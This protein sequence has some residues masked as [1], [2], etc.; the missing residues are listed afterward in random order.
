MLR[1]TLAQEEATVRTAVDELLI[2]QQ[3]DGLSI[4]HDQEKT[5]R[6]LL[7]TP[8]RRFLFLEGGGVAALV[9]LIKAHGLDMPLPASLLSLSRLLLLCCQDAESAVTVGLLGL[10]PW[11]QRVLALNNQ[12]EDEE[13]EDE[14]VEALRECAE[15]IASRCARVRGGF[16]L[17]TLALCSDSAL[18][19]LRLPV[20]VPIHSHSSITTTQK[21]QEH[22]PKDEE[23]VV[24][25]TPIAD[26]MGSQAD[27]GYFLWP[28]ATI[29]ARF[30]V[31]NPSLFAGK[32]VME[33][34]AGLGLCGL[35][36]GRVAKE[37][38][39]TDYN[40]AC[41]QQLQE[42]VRLNCDDATGG[43][44]EENRVVSKEGG[45]AATAAAVVGAAAPGAAAALACPSTMKVRWLDWDRLEALSGST[46][47][48]SEEAEEEE[49]EGEEGKEEEKTEEDEEKSC[50]SSSL[51][52]SLSKEED[53]AFGRRRWSSGLLDV[54]MG[55]D[56][57]CD[58]PSAVG[59]AR[60]LSMTLK[61]ET[62]V[63]YITAPFPQHR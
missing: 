14:A 39:L 31:G 34:G 48:V 18:A 29:L 50:K 60:L 1:T 15:E 52:R 35:V 55:S 36:A 63:G 30:I 57:I 33:I 12:E 42:H 44:E 62:G 56:C 37:V 6:A 16:P 19:S 41:L 11:L 8:R 10:H 7:Q 43:G 3:E 26:R 58:E 28:A 61:P 2:Q 17:R 54:I 53:G 20:R 46:W 9:E 38:L 22:Q 25:I 32:R 51:N 49:E 21:T 59:V 24:L 40:L 5:L 23:L 45:V 27:T 13:E 47:Q 4:S